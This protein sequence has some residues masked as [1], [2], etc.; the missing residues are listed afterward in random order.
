MLW[1]SRLWSI[2]DSNISDIW[3]YIISGKRKMLK[4]DFHT[5]RYMP[6]NWTITN[7]ALCD[8]DL[9]C[10]NQTYH[11][12]NLTGK[13]WNNANISITIRERKS[14]NCYGMASLRIL[15]I[16]TLKCIFKVVAFEMWI[17]RKQ[18]EL[19]KYAQVWL[20][21]GWY[22]PTNGTIV[23]FVLSLAIFDGSKPA[24]QIR[25]AGWKSDVC[26]RWPFLGFWL[27][28]RVRLNS[29]PKSSRIALQAW[30]TRSMKLW[31][32]VFHQ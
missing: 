20:Y 13:W 31:L 29:K 7:I 27:L 30:I 15:C 22:S 23:N 5:S 25:K 18:W 4:S 8:L 9:N 19:A 16:I 1:P 6:L 2:F 12:A 24:F 3:K 21:S 28:P 10:Q 14:S 32:V 26:L 17:S 11:L